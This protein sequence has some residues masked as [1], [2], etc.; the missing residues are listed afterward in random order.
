MSPI[1]N[2]ISSGTRVMLSRA[3]P[4]LRLLVSFGPTPF[5]LAA[6]GGIHGGSFHHSTRHGQKTVKVIT[7]TVTSTNSRTT[8]SR[9][10]SG[11]V[12]TKKIVPLRQVTTL[13]TALSP[14][15]NP[16]IPIDSSRG[17][18]PP[19]LS[20]SATTTSFISFGEQGR[21]TPDGK[22][23]S[24]VIKE[25]RSRS[26][27]AQL[28]PL[29]F[30]PPSSIV[31]APPD[32]LPFL[33]FRTNDSREVY[34]TKCDQEADLWLESLESNENDGTKIMR[35]WGVGCASLVELGAI[36]IQVKEDLDNQR[37]IRSMAKLTKELL[38]HSIE[39]I[40]SVRMCNWQSRNLS[41]S[42]LA[43]AANDVFV[44]Y[45]VA[46]RIKLL[47]KS[48]PSQDYIVELMTIIDNGAE[49]IR[50]RGTLQEREFKPF[51][52][53][54]II[55]EV[56]T[57]GSS[58]KPKTKNISESLKATTTIAKTAI[59][60]EP[61]PIITTN[62]VTHT[63]LS[64]KPVN[65]KKPQPIHH[66]GVMNAWSRPKPQ[67]TI[68]VSKPKPRFRVSGEPEF[69]YW[70]NPNDEQAMQF[71]SR[72]TV[73]IISRNQQKRTLCTSRR[74]DI[75][76]IGTL[77]MKDTTSKHGSD[78]EEENNGRDLNSVYVPSRIL[79]ESLEGMDTLERNQAV[80]LEAGGRDLSDEIT[81]QKSDSDD[82]WHLIQNQKLLQSTMSGSFIADQ[83]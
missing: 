37:K 31:S 12:T 74:L 43:Y 33:D 11:S 36:F 57:V 75:S 15:A 73:V 5:H 71:G 53:E 26:S 32:S 42:Q 10:T 6:R 81:A 40:E 46:E 76:S 62:T 9:K 21:M 63:Q 80:W 56:I 61:K 50:V 4:H 65:A 25:F 30:P 13:S 54:D 77:A 22:G 64:I 60:R 34:Y 58:P 38:G 8:L 66:L 35:D 48:R 41:S 23:R 67:V 29:R 1:T 49:Y 16:T 7:T 55:D 78:I 69:P 2:H 27:I 28:S 68:P 39:K 82:D 20:R 51:T 18:I 17:I 83:K 72:S 24:K 47:Q 14:M 52:E 70:N 3:Q 19:L 45:E 44:T 59:T 79:P